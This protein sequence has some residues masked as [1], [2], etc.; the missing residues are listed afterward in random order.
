MRKVLAATGILIVFA[1][2]VL[3]GIWW[4]QGRAPLQIEYHLPGALEVC[5]ELPAGNPGVTQTFCANLPWFPSTKPTSPPVTTIPTEIL[6][7]EQCDIPGIDKPLVSITNADPTNP[8][9]ISFSGATIQPPLIIPGG[10]KVENWPFEPGAYVFTA[11]YNTVPKSRP[12]SGPVTFRKTCK[13]GT[14][15]W[16]CVYTP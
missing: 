6:W 5:I 10:Q 9:T 16:C 11:A 1:A 13:Y 12:M 14:Q 2:G 7:A 8:L 3:T 4:A 15:F